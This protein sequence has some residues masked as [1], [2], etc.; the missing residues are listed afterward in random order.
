MLFD[1]VAMVDWSAAAVPKRGNDS[2]WI[3]IAGACPKQLPRLTNPA[4]RA[5][6]MGLIGALLDW[7]GQNRHRLLI[8][9]DFPIGYP[10]GSIAPLLPGAEPG[11]R[12]L[13][14]HLASAIDDGAQNANNRFEVAARMN[15]RFAAEGPFWGRPPT[16]DVP[17]LPARK[18]PGYGVLLPAERRIVERQVPRAQPVWKLFTTGS[19]GSQALMGIAAL[20]RLR[21]ARQARQDLVIWPFE[22]GLAVPA[23]SPGTTVIAEIYP[24]LID[25]AVSAALASTDGAQAGN[26]PPVKDAVQ[27][28]LTAG[29]LQA[30]DRE[31]HLAPLFTGPTGEH[32]LTT[33]E[34]AMVVAEE[35][36]IL[37]VGHERALSEAAIQ[38]AADP[39]P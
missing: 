22:T 1:T 34:V 38:L 16:R 7:T 26:A 36:W 35:A 10:A 3:A 14:S 21:Q 32:A 6:A 29:A 2:I 37:G 20:E 4:T 25:A 9:F 31:G 30:L 17:G 33:E 39:E 15:A 11:W 12:A 19:V 18:P 5:E 13:W 27:V 23:P 24:G 8:G 28:R